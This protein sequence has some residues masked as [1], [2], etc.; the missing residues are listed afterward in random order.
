MKKL[1]FAVALIFVLI[2][3]LLLELVSFSV[4]NNKKAK[5]IDGGISYVESTVRLRNPGRG[6]YFTLPITLKPSNNDAVNTYHISN[7]AARY[8]LMHL[9]VD[10]SAFSTGAGGMDAELTADALALLESALT[11]ARNYKVGTIVRLSYDFAGTYA[12]VEPAMSLMK[13]H[14]EQAAAVINMFI[15]DGT[16]V[17]VE[18]GMLGPWG[19]Q[20]STTAAGI[21]SNFYDIVQTWLDATHDITISVRRPRF[22]VYWYND[23]YNTTYTVQTIDQIPASNPGTDEYR[24]GVYND[25]YLGSGS[26]LGTY[27]DRTKEVEW[28]TRQASHTFLG[29]EVARDV[30]YDRTGSAIG[31]YNKIEFLEVEGYKTRT[32]YLNV[33]WNNQVIAAWNANPYSGTDL[34]YKGNATNLDFVENRLGYR[35][36]IRESKI[37][38]KVKAGKEL[39]IKG[40]IENVGFA[41]MLFNT[42]LTFLLVDSQGVA[43][44]TLP[45]EYLFSPGDY[46][47]TLKIN[48]NIAAGD[49]ILYCKIGNGI[50][51]ANPDVFNNTLMANKLGNVKVTP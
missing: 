51:F 32:S 15:G 21:D 13:R 43:V 10:I 34:I 14:I 7:K 28:L 27:T 36:V 4:G 26:D 5:L 2:A 25:G 38:E 18:S 37:S 23:R 29:G 45:H 24:V 35:F 41:P 9:R 16:V 1:I 48:S 42:A 12:E 20:H 17:A 40:R 30:N 11:A 50:A 6:F 44:P 19:E 49:Y 39:R 31:D 47:M 33:E 22:F 46:D 8:T 3:P